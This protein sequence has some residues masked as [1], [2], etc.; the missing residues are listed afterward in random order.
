MCFLWV[1]VLVF[2]LGAC[3]YQGCCVVSTFIFCQVPYRCVVFC[4]RLIFIGLRTKVRFMRF[5]S[6]ALRCPCDNF[7]TGNSIYYFNYK[8]LH[9]QRK[10]DD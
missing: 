2:C 8:K 10:R 3:S 5:F 9:R 4:R 7:L 1:M 6:S